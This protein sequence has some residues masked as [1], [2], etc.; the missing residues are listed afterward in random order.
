MRTVVVGEG[1][2]REPPT[3][4]HACKLLDGVLFVCPSSYTVPPILTTVEPPLHIVWGE[5]A[6]APY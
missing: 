6:P 4:M 5:G 3:T 2:T 1:V